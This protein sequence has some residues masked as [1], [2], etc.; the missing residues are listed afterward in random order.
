[1]SPCRRSSTAVA[2]LRLVLPLGSEGAALTEGLERALALRA[3]CAVEHQHAVEVVELVLDHAGLEPGRLD[4]E[5]LPADVHRVRPDEQRPL[6]VDDDAREAETSLLCGREVVVRAPVDLGVDHDGRLSLGADLEDE[7]APE[8]PQLR[9]SQPDA[10]RV[11]HQ[12]D[13]P[14]SL[15]G[16][17]IVELGH[18][19]GRRL[20]HGIAELDDL[21]ECRVAPLEGLLVEALGRLGLDRPVVLELLDRGCRLVGHGFESSQGDCKAENRQW[22]GTGSGV[23]AHSRREAAPMPVLRQRGL[24]ERDKVDAEALERLASGQFGV[25]STSQLRRLGL[26]RAAIS[27]WVKSRRL[28]PIHPRIYALGHCS[29]SLPA[30]LTAALLYAGSSAVLSHTTAGWAWQ[31]IEAEPTTIHLTVPGRR[32]SLPRIRIH[33]SRQVTPVHRRG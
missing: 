13:H 16:E 24:A 1:M 25:V 14:L 2:V 12:P 9:G 28:C 15:L 5:L 19:R 31:L 7:H 21:G 22:M 6:D 27:G 4:R 11:P 26:T 29:L 3:L 8:G 33:H 18:R 10:D 32:R 20:E 23:W 30:R 17:L